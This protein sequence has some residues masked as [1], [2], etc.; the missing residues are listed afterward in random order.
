MSRPGITK[1]LLA[2]TTLITTLASTFSYGD[3][4]AIRRTLRSRSPQSTVGSISATPI[5][6]LFE[7]VVD[8]RIVYVTEDGRYVIV[9]ELVEMDSGRS[10]TQARQDQISAIP[11]DKLPLELAFKRVKGDGSRRVAVFED[12]DCPYCKKLEQELARIDN[13]TIYTFLFPIEQIHPGATDKSQAIWC[14]RDRVKAWEDAVLSSV[15]PPIGASCA[16]P[17]SRIIDYG[18]AHGI[19]GTPTTFFSDGRRVIGAISAQ[20]LEKQLARSGR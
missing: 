7:V 12:P 15:A 5:Q 13:L 8:G 6:G 19:S 18:R 11:F 4:D 3:E 20:E 17:V 1:L 16:T 14:A 10:L 9:G 2:V